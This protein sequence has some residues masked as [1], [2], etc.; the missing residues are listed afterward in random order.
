MVVSELSSGFE[1][2]IGGGLVLF[3]INIAAAIAIDATINI[4]TIPRNKQTF[5][6]FH[7]GSIAP[8]TASDTAVSDSPTCSPIVVGTSLFAST[9]VRGWLVV[10]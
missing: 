1:E 7:Q 6:H 3:L 4:N 10:I 5:V 8:A 9:T 2:G